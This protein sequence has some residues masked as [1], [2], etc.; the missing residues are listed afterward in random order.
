MEPRIYKCDKAIYPDKKSA[1][2]KINFLNKQGSGKD[3]SKTGLRGYFCTHCNGWHLT[4]KP[5]NGR[6]Y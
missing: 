3:K 6:E 4:S 5:K 2:Y 1:E